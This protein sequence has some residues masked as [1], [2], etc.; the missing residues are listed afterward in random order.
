MVAGK[1]SVNSETQRPGVLILTIKVHIGRLSQFAVLGADTQTSLGVAGSMAPTKPMQ[2]N[3]EMPKHLLGISQITKLGK[4]IQKIGLNP[5][6]K[7]E[8]KWMWPKMNPNVW[9]KCVENRKCAET[10]RKLGQHV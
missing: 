2:I 3:F 5:N 4:Q 1:F 8:K 7:L 10:S 9:Q 6:K